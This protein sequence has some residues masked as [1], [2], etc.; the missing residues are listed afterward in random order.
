MAAIW[1]FGSWPAAADILTLKQALAVAYDSNPD[2]EG[3]RAGLRAVDEGVAQANSGWRPQINAT[4]SYGVQHGQVTGF[5]SA[6]NSHPLT[7]A[8]SVTEPIFRGGRT[9]AQIGR[10]IALVH[11]ARAELA[12]TERTVLLQ[13]VT[14]YL[15]VVRD[16]RILAI[17]QDNVRTLQSEVDAVHTQKNA[18]AVTRTDVDQAEARLARAQADLAAARRDL[19]SSREAFVRL[20]GRPAPTLEATPPMPPM[21]ASLETARAIGDKWSPRVL[22]ARADWKAADYAVADA[23]GAMLPQ[24]SVSGQAQYL[25]DAAGTNIFATKNPQTILTI[26]GQVTVPIY[27]GGA[28]E[29]TVRRAK[30]LRGQSQLAIV[31]AQR[32]VQ[33]DVGNAWEAL[34]AAQ[35]Q[36]VAN[37]AQVASDQHALDGVKQEQEAGERQVLDILNAQQE[38]LSAEVAAATAR[39]DAAVAAYRLLWATGQLNA[40]TLG[41]PVTYYDPKVH[42]DEDANAWFGLGESDGE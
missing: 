26:T 35:A 3:A 16:E 25:R 22:Q 15:D 38:L 28:E 41:L 32:A 17:N 33:E 4:G 19:V 40:R 8:I 12:D 14:A 31:S 6:F 2:L 5:A 11:S 13:A 24:V 42:Y 30:E 18:G 27:Q 37:D 20:I 21:P 1:V 7:G 36:I 34:S 23:V 10:A 39:H 9:V 29:A